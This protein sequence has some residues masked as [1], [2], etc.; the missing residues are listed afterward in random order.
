MTTI[1]LNAEINRNLAQLADDEPALKKVA[2]YIKKLISKKE[3]QPLELTPEL[4][5]EIDQARKEF[6]EGKCIT[7]N[8][9]EELD[10]YFN[11]L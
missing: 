3:E 1:E 10:A 4:Q 2:N 7:F 8:S 6:A 11:K 5:A 9:V